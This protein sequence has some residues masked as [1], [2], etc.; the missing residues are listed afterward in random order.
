MR[1]KGQIFLTGCDGQFYVSSWLGY[2]LQLFNQTL[3]YLSVIVKAFC[4]YD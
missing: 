1:E 3:I 2:S 4:R